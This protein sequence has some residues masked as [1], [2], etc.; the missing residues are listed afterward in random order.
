[1]YDVVNVL[2]AIEVVTK[3]AKNHYAYVGVENL[4]DTME[5]L[6]VVFL[7]LLTACAWV[8]L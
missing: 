6:R 5:K 2:N 1:M 4:V 3:V 8:P 7:H